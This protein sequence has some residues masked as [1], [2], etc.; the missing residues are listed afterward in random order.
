MKPASIISL[1]VAV[2][3][4]VSG[5][6]TLNV[7]EKKAEE[8]GQSI[9]SEIESADSQTRVFEFGDLKINKIQ[10]DLSDA[11]IT[12]VGGA[13][14]SYIEFINFK[15]NYYSLV[16]TS[17]LVSFDETPDIDAMLTFWESGFSFKGIRYMLN[18]NK[19]NTDHEA[20]KEI[21]IYLTDDC[22][23]KQIEIN[24]TTCTV[25]VNDMITGTD[26]FVTAE[27]ITLNTQNV[28]TSSALNINTGKDIPAAKSVVFSSKS[29]YIT[30]VKINAENLELDAKSFMC[31][32]SAEINCASGKVNI[33]SSGNMKFDLTSES[34]EIYVNSASVTSPC[35][36]GTSGSTVKVTAG[37]ADISVRTGAL[38]NNFVNN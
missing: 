17:S 14:K 4:V 25:N 16:T 28:M 12:V 37:S 35:T 8:A 2:L 21:K 32:G 9:F 33:E 18:I 10:L 31:S 26:Y 23:V 29:D 38:S 13:E 15:G 3:I 11:E 19:D 7:A 1:I 5:F 24:A 22:A 27:N 20:K 34:G 30:N 6:V 36:V